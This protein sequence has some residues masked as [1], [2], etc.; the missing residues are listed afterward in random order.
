MIWAQPWRLRGLGTVRPG[1]ECFLEPGPCQGSSWQHRTHPGTEFKGVPSWPVGWPLSCPVRQG[2]P[3]CRAPECY[4]WTPTTQPTLGGLTSHSHTS[5]PWLRT[6]T[7]H[8]ASGL[9]PNLSWPQL[10]TLPAQH[11]ALQQVCT[12]PPLKSPTPAIWFSPQAPPTHQQPSPS[13]PC[14]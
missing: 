14:N 12:A 7:H 9:G 4:A 8:L 5:C 2:C 1:S 11:P 6:W 13:Q 3:L 10:P